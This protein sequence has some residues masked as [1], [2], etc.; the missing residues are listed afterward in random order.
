MDEAVLYDGAKAGKNKLFEF[1]DVYNKVSM[2]Q[3]ERGDGC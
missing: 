2:I 1:R 3:E